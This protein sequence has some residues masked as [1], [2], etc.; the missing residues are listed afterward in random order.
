VITFVRASKSE[1]RA[2][3]AVTGPSGS[4]KTFWSLL[5]ATELAQGGRIAYID[6][7]RGSASL[8]ADRFNFDV[9]NFAPPFHPN[10][11]VEALNVAAL[12]Y[13]VLV[14]DSLSHFWNGPGGLLEIVDEAKGRFGGNSFAA[15]QVGTPIQQRM[16]DSILSHPAHV[17]VAMRSRTEWLIQEDSRGRS[18]PQRVG[19]APRQRDEIEYEFTV[20]LDLDLEHRG[21]VTKTR[22]E[23]LADRRIQPVDAEAVAKEFRLWLDAGDPLA[24]LS[25]RAAVDTGRRRLD[26][27]QKKELW[28]SWQEN[29]LPAET[30]M[31]T[32]KQAAVALAL[33]E[34]LTEAHD[35]IPVEDVDES[36]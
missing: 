34:A 4:G 18:V 13:P 24:D 30:S 5:W 12:E 32:E 23:L 35:E 21:N 7:E 20:M 8:Y 36:A 11:L 31:L 6:T 19:M 14:V 16:V 1:A 26:E 10:R 33:L 15:W 17:V 9:L 28:R 22:C 25:T 3:V 27:A 2:R 29:G